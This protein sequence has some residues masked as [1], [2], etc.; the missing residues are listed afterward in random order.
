LADRFLARGNGGIQNVG[1]V[2]TGSMRQSGG[3]GRG[4]RHRWRGGS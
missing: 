4:S 1:G 2:K 3:A